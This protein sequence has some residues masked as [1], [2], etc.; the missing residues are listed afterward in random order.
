MSYRR[1]AEDDA[2]RSTFKLTYYLIPIIISSS[3]E[4]CIAVVITAR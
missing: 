3:Y 4:Q 1:T 2:V